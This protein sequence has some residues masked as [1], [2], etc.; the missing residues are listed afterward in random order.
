ML[1]VFVQMISHNKCSSQ[2]KSNIGSQQN[3][4]IYFIDE[5]KKPNH[6]NKHG[7]L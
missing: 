4:E 3:C 7:V 6:Q 1:T 5:L 2:V